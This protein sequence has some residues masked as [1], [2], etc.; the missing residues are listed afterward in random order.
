MG[1][2]NSNGKTYKIE[3]IPFEDKGEQDEEGYYEYYYTGIRILFYL[4]K[5]IITARMYDGETVISFSKNPILIFGE[6][7]EAMRKYIVQ[8]FGVTRFKYLGGENGYI[9]L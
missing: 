1:L 7:F 4:D 9:E 3:C 5:E 6:E 8:E 2:I